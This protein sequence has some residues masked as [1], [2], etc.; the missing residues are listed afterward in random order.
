MLVHTKPFN[1][2]LLIRS[3]YNLGV[4]SNLGG[5]Q[6]ISLGGGAASKMALVSYHDSLCHISGRNSHGNHVSVAWVGRE[7]V[8]L[9]LGIVTGGNVVSLERHISGSLGV[10]VDP[11]MPLLKDNE[12]ARP[13]EQS[14]C[15]QTNIAERTH[16]AGGLV[17]PEDQRSLTRG[18]SALS[19]VLRDLLPLSRQSVVRHVLLDQSVGSVL[20]DHIESSVVAGSDGDI[21]AVSYEVLFRLGEGHEIIGIATEDLPSGRDAVAVRHDARSPVHHVSVARR[22]PDGIG[23]PGHAG[24]IGGYLGEAGARPVLQ[25]GGLPDD[26]GLG[27]LGLHVGVGPAAWQTVDFEV[28]V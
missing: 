18:Q 28:L 7:L 25:V 6:G 11:E 1:Q 23:R 3:M 12:L 21:H 16:L 14:T 24:I 4:G 5:Q 17:V 19:D 2:T 10:V 15:Q 13:T 22:V 9:R 8:V 20:G 27:A 26:N